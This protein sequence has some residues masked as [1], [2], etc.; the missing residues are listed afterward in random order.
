MQNL[1]IATVSE[2]KNRA[3]IFNMLITARWLIQFMLIYLD[4][5]TIFRISSLD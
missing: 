1:E 3:L 5:T 2:W 4:N